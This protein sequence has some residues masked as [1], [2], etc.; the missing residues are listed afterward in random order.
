MRF[1]LNLRQ[2]TVFYYVAK[3][4]SF[5]R[6]AE[7][8]FISQPAVTMQIASLEEL[9]GLQ[10]FIREKNKLALTEAGE[11]LFP[12]AEKLMEI[13]YQAERVLL[14]MKANPHG[15]LRV[16][17]TKT[18]ARYVLPPFIL[19]F[20][21]EFPKVSIKVDEGSSEEMMM[22]VVYGRNDIAIVGRLA[23]PD[24]VESFP[25]TGREEDELFVLVPKNH[26]FSGRDPVS[27]EELADEPVIL[28]ERGSTTRNVTLAA[29]DSRGITPK[30]LL[31]SGNI[32][33]IKELVEKGVGISILGGIGLQDVTE[34]SG[35][36][37]IKI[38]A[39]LKFPIDFVLQAGG[40]RPQAVTAFIDLVKKM[41][42]GK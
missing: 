26:R 41:S 22:S 28:R 31:E 16:G 1:A 2:L 40:H 9:Y 37:V 15:L 4:L 11:A 17:T 38:D 23:Y 6:A 3:N 21:E 8:L 32:D 33:L 27:L 35:V 24:R 29:L 39:K 10:L 25:F 20:A 42:R 12:Y 7:E 34:D 18:F 36:K 14:N 30:V 19:R 13:G 5:T